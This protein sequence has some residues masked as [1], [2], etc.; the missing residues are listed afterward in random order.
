VCSSVIKDF[1]DNR[2]LEPAVESR[3]DYLIT[4]NNND[5]QFTEYEGTRIINPKEFWELLVS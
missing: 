3:T 1:A 2:L 5:F 4:G